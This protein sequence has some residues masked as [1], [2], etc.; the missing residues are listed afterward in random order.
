MR[1]DSRTY[2]EGQRGEIIENTSVSPTYLETLGVPIIE[3]RGIAETD[4]AGQP[5]TWS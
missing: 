4:V 5:R 2:S 3:G 1:V